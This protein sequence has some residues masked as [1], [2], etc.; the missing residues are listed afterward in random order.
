MGRMGSDGANGEEIRISWDFTLIR[1]HLLSKLPE[2]STQRADGVIKLLNFWEGNS[3][4]GA[5]EKRRQEWP[6]TG[7][8]CKSD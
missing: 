8:C 2:S 6:E 7:T 4:L 5:R 1:D 3:E